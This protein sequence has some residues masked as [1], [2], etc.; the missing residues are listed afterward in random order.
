MLG[1][2]S[3]VPVKGGGVGPCVTEVGHNFCFATVI[4]RKVDDCT[5]SNDKDFRYGRMFGYQ[6]EASA[7][8][9]RGL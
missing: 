4:G 2:C 8:V 7:E 6:L 9:S 5:C 3:N 1:I